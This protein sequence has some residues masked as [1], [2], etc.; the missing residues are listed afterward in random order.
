[1]RKVPILNSVKA[2][3]GET[4]FQPTSWVFKLE[5]LEN[6]CGEMWWKWHILDC[7]KKCGETVFQLTSCFT[8]LEVF[9]N[10]YMP[11]LGR[12]TIYSPQGNNTEVKPSFK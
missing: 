9:Q 2:Q 1:M 3:W 8:K 10:M 5:V 4:I 7:M 11:G 6:I 12:N